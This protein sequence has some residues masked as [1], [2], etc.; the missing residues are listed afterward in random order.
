MF[1][2]ILYVD[3]LEHIAD[4]RAELEASCSHLRAGGYL[5][6]LSPAHQWLYTPFDRAIGHYRR[7][8][9][10]TVAELIPARLKCMEL[11]YLDS[12]GAIA[13]LGNKLVLKRALPTARQLMLWDK[14]MIPLSRFVD[15]LLGYH[16]GKSV[17]GV[18][19]KQSDVSS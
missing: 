18:W 1:D 11:K 19:R 12:V 9:K 17:L 6:V 4:D 2:T 5:I 10:G 15:P 3:V 8:N 7:Y 13:S 14:L 16:A